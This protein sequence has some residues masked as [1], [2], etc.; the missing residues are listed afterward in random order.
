MK[1][2]CDGVAAPVNGGLGNCN[3]SLIYGTTC[4]PT[5]EAAYIAS[6]IFSCNSTGYLDV[7]TCV[8]NKCNVTAPTNGALGGCSSLL[9]YGRSCTPSCQSGYK[10][11]DHSTCGATGVF[12]AATCTQCTASVS[13]S[14]EATT[15]ASAASTITIT[16]SKTTS[17]SGCAV[18][19]TYNWTINLYKRELPEAASPSTAIVDDSSQAWQNLKRSES[20]L[21]I[22]ALTLVVGGYY[23]LTLQVTDGFTGAV[24]SYTTDLHIVPN[25]WHLAFTAGGGFALT[26]GDVVTL[27]PPSDFDVDNIATK[28]F[29]WNFTSAIENA[30]TGVPALCSAGGGQAADCS[31]VTINT[32]TLDA[33][34]YT[35]GLTV[36]RGIAYGDAMTASLT[37]SATFSVSKTVT[38]SVTITKGYSTPEFIANG[39]LSLTGVASLNGAA[40]TSCTYVWSSTYSSGSA[41]ET[42]PL[43]DSSNNVS[44]STALTSPMLLSSSATLDSLTL[45]SNTLCPGLTYSFRAD[46]TYTAD[47]GCE[48]GCTGFTEVS[49]LVN[50]APQCGNSNTSC[51]IVQEVNTNSSTLEAV[52][53]E[54]NGTVFST[55]IQMTTADWTDRNA[56]LLYQF[57]VVPEVNG[58]YDT[59]KPTILTTYGTSTTFSTEYLGIGAY[60]VLVN[61]KDSIG[62]VSTGWAGS[63]GTKINVLEPVIP[64]GSS[65]SEVLAQQADNLLAEASGDA[66]NNVVTGIAASLN[67]DQTLQSSRRS[68]SALLAATETRGKLVTSLAVQ[69]A[70]EA[71]ADSLA[72]SAVANQMTNTTASSVVAQAYD[73]VNTA[74]TMS[75]AYGALA[76]AA[77]DAAYVNLI[78]SPSRRT[79]DSDA[80]LAAAKSFAATNAKMQEKVLNT[81]VTGQ[82]AQTVSSSS[83]TSVMQKAT[84]STIGTSII[85]GVTFSTAMP[86]N[87][88]DGT[89]SAAVMDT[90]SSRV[91]YSS[92]GVVLNGVMKTVSVMD[93]SGVVQNITGMNPPT[94]LTLTATDNG[95]YACTYWDEAS[96]AWLTDGVTATL[97]ANNIWTCE[98]T[99]LTAFSLKSTPAPTPTPTPLPL[100]TPTPLATPT[101]PT[102]SP[103]PTP[104][105]PSPSPSPSPT[106]ITLDQSITFSNLGDANAFTGQLKDGYVKGWGQVMGVVDE[107]GQVISGNTV[108]GTASDSRRGARVSFSAAITAALAAAAKLAA[109]GLT[110]NPAALASA[111]SAVAGSLGYAISAPLAAE[112][113]ASNPTWVDAPNPTPTPGQSIIYVQSSG[114]SWWAIFLIVLAIIIVI[115]LVAVLIVCLNGGKAA[116]KAD[117]NV[118]M[119]DINAAA[120]AQVEIDAGVETNA[121]AGATAEATVEANA[122]ANEEVKVDVD[123]V[124]VDMDTE[125]PASVEMQADVEVDVDA[126]VPDGEISSESN[127]LVSPVHTDHV[128]EM[129]VAELAVEA[130]FAG[131]VSAEVA[132]E[133]VEVAVEVDAAAVEVDAAALEVATADVSLNADGAA[134]V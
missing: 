47:N 38:P 18:P 2:T 8:R 10:L 87:Y 119:T 27:T 69:A 28:T 107:S 33:G 108:T 100:P 120:D 11:D 23:N 72:S 7:P 66:L 22:P 52:A 15:S 55:T 112:I 57:A 116:A 114:I 37:T 67:S 46:V 13:L 36:D 9:T 126:G 124:G 131:E 95:W 129:E 117:A 83:T 12:Q 16:S 123:M 91:G 54:V 79:G 70:S 94:N 96:S 81:M 34:W 17:P 58:Q 110:N 74:E 49:V 6:G 30:V 26:A 113:V 42:T 14:A 56:P 29:A 109:S 89:I 134:Q 41:S 35:V 59:S 103:L 25:N 128:P 115:L 51:I 75:A 86:G 106:P 19:V 60:K 105:S 93:S 71:K 61:C 32:S 68:T 92:A 24:T 130:E 82:P 101:P 118:E 45:D 77:A 64:A 80:Q 90:I 99:H 50:E 31:S 76:V 44:C 21:T 43:A 111:I 65:L 125:I 73:I 98:S 20:S 104:T 127:A 4:Q 121:A 53:S 88:A 78:S 84:A 97:G 132:A 1:N 39:Y 122:D 133:A 40:C 102:S 3:S 85:G 62:A 5:C 63:T 48:S